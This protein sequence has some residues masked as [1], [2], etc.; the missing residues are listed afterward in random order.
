M[1]YITSGSRTGL[2]IAQQMYGSKNFYNN[3]VPWETYVFSQHGEGKYVNYLH[4]MTLKEI[5]VRNIYAIVG[6]SVTFA[7]NEVDYIKIGY[8]FWLSRCRRITN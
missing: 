3:N 5:M 2:F 4:H 6:T 8:S 7:D 1:A